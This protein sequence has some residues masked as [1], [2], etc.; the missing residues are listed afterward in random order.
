MWGICS[1]AKNRLASQEGLC[2]IELVSLI[3]YR[4]WTALLF[5]SVKNAELTGSSDIVHDEVAG[6]REKERRIERAEVD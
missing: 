5:Y 2:S 1:L 6:K 3:H 4:R